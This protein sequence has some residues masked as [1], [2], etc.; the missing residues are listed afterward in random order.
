MNQ[1]HYIKSIDG[2][3]TLAVLLVLLFH[4]DFHWLSGGFVGVDVFFVISG[5][6]ITRNIIGEL[7]DDRFRFSSFYLRRVAR[8]FPALFTTI[9]LTLVAGYFLF[10]PTDLERLGQIGIL[11]T[12]SVGNIFF[13]L[14]AGYFDAA[15][16]SKPLL[17]TWS[18]SVEEQFY[19]IWPLF[20]LLLSKKGRAQGKTRGVLIAGISVFGVL[21]LLGASYVSATDASAVFFLTPFRIYQFALGA[22]VACIGLSQKGWVSDIACALG[23]VLIGC[24]ALIGNAASSMWLTAVMPACGAAALIFGS[25]GALSSAALANAPATWL[26]QRSYSIYL[27]HWPIIVFWKMATDY[28]FSTMESWVAVGVSIVAGALLYQCV[29]RPFRSRSG[30][31]AL[32][33][34]G[35]LAGVFSV[36][37]GVLLA[38]SQFWRLDGLPSRIPAELAAATNNI[39]AQ[40]D[41]RK[42]KL[43]DGSCNQSFESVDL[44]AFDEPGCTA[45]PAEQNAFLILGDSFASDAYLIF[46]EAFP[47][48]Y[49]GQISVPGCLLRL[50]AQIIKEKFKGCRALYK[51]GLDIAG[52]EDYDGVILSSNWAAGHYY[53]IAELIKELERPGFRV[54]VVGQRLRFKDRVPN[55]IAG[56]LSARDADQKAFRLVVRQPEKVNSVILERFSEHAEVFDMYR[57]QHD[58][59]GRVLNDNGQLLYLDDVH[60]SPAGALELAG[61]IRQSFPDLLA[62]AAR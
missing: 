32:F 4:V 61:I 50:P 21:S 6:L 9:A 25:R 10:S 62:P 5:F 35:V 58:V 33:R 16:A 52:S 13:W 46:S 57:L 55:L 19:F 1:D 40:W 38:G 11:S 42:A 23:I 56:A 51:K 43:R 30:Q 20:L 18:L 34:N 53:R 14:E 15:A 37:I 39:A 60:I 48:T 29:E 27:A 54:I 59:M 36:G 47:E 24:A 28:S 12:L 31:S 17:H 2:L 45:P 3:R 8:L 7:A 49:F 44:D 22:L 26:G 41:V